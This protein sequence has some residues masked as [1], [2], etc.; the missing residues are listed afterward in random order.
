M[1]AKRD[2][3]AAEMQKGPHTLTETP[4]VITVVLNW[5]GLAD[6]RECL[7]SLQAADYPAIRVLVVD[8]GSKNDEASQLEKE[9]GA[10]IEV[11]RL[12]ENLGFAGGSN[13]G[14]KRA[15]ELGAE[16]VLLLNND[17]IVEPSF[18]TNL[19]R[20]TR[21]LPKLAAAC[22]KS[23]FYSEPRRIY[24]T[25]GKVSIW[26]GVANQVGRGQIDHGQ[27]DRRAQRDYADGVCMLI[28]ASALRTVGLLDEQYFA[29]WEETDWCVRARDAGLRCYYVPTAKIWHK[30]ERSQA[31]DA[32]FHYFYR[33]NALLF[34]RKRGSGL[35][36]ASAIA[37]QVFFYGPL[38]FI[39]HPTRIA[40]AA[41]E[42]RA[43]FWHTRNQPTHR[44]LA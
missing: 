2:S 21:D 40:R 15:L 9:F 24:S 38:Y 37:V 6:T 10:F 30:A 11:L 34:V 33:R 1:E 25:G 32:R 31:P 23:Y 4:R 17:V 22:P 20:D 16:Y 18:L 35:Q 19:V 8:N 3:E 12:P 28:P 27:Y 7:Q 36:L 41:A 26:R 39:K 42:I 5:N 44:P 43:L 29:Y 13:A 14:M